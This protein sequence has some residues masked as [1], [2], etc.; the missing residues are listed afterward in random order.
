[1]KLCTW[2]VR[3][4]FWNFFVGGQ[5]GWPIR[6]P[7]HAHLRLDQPK[8]DPLWLGEYRDIL[9]E[10]PYLDTPTNVYCSQ[11]HKVMPWENPLVEHKIQR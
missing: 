6:R 10:Q 9:R 1:M 4:N 7:I 2:F 3:Q 8:I 11:G 5:K